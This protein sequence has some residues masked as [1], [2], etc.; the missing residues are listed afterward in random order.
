M[1][2]NLNTGA[3]TA[4]SNTPPQT[5]FTQAMLLGKMTQPPDTLKY[6]TKDGLQ[7]P[8]DLPKH[9]MTLL[10][11]KFET[12]QG[13][14]KTTL[15]GG[16]SIYLPVPKQMQDQHTVNYEQKEIGNV[17]GQITDALTGGSL[18]NFFQALKNAGGAAG[19]N[20]AAGLFGAFNINAA[21]AARAATGMAPNQ[22]L[23]VLLKGPQYK[24]HEL[25]WTLSPKNVRESESIRA[26]I[27]KLNNAMAPGTSGAYFKHP[28]VVTPAYSNE[29]VLYKFKPCV[30]EAM[31]INYSPSGAPSFY[32]RSAAP[33]AVE[34]RLSLTEIEFWMTGD[35]DGN[36]ISY[37][38]RGR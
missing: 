8:Q 15:S 25:A 30:I 5:K 35:F 27:Q 20:F 21:D 4:A 34:L 33:D 32:A 17:T 28:M 23:T 26:I 14:G 11:Q 31:S 36:A 16:S 12:Q 22:F 7:F 9:Y 2:N 1:A 29:N 24:K 6:N 13:L 19:G 38:D 18:S 3:S 10:L 37:D